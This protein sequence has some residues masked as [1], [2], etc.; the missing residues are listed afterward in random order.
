MLN[1]TWCLQ[2][3][4]RYAF[5]RQMLPTIRTRFL[6]QPGIVHYPHVDAVSHPGNGQFQVDIETAVKAARG[7]NKLIEINNHSFAI[8]KGSEVNCKEFVLLCKKYDVRVICGSDAHIS[9]DVGKFDRV[10]KLFEETDFP[11]ELVL[12]TSVEKMEEYL[13]E[14]RKRFE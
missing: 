8:R 7:N 12:N 14:R 3:F 4:T 5:L 13:I 1:S 10:Y 2:D 6:Y 9:F 11:E